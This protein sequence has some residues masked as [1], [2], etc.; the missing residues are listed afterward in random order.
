MNSAN[1]ATIGAP[2]SVSDAQARDDATCFARALVSVRTRVVGQH[3]TQFGLCPPADD[4]DHTHSP[5][6]IAPM[7]I[8]TTATAAQKYGGGTIRGASAFSAATLSAKVAVSL[9]SVAVLRAIS[10]RGRPRGQHRLA[11]HLRGPQADARR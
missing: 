10:L 4:P 8:T 9:A 2:R 7:I 6:M 1:P 3:R 11:E 5:V